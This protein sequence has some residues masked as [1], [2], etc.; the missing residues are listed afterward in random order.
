VFLP[1]IMT[2]AL[3]GADAPAAA[4]PKPVEAPSPECA[5]RPDCRYVGRVTVR[6]NQ[7]GTMS[8][9][10]NRNF[11]FLAGPPGHERLRLIVG[12]MVVARLGGPGEP[13]LVVLQKGAASDLPKARVYTTLEEQARHAAI[14]MAPVQGHEVVVPRTAGGDIPD[15][16][17]TARQTLRF[18]AKQIEGTTL[19]VLIIDNGY[20]RMLQYKAD[21]VG[22]GPTDVCQVRPGV[23]SFEN[24]P[25]PFLEIDLHDFQLVDADPHGRPL[26]G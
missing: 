10:L 5:A 23:P 21:I 7:G 2:L 14:P 4:A 11:T 25:S 20:D 9:L 24:W 13:A 26:C 3:S 1:L 22:H 6:T 18:T 19:T 16:A 12:E 15:T 17:P 8:G